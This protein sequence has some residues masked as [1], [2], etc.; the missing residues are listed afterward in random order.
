MRL[1]TGFWDAFRNASALAA[2]TGVSCVATSVPVTS[3]GV[4]SCAING[5]VNKNE[6]ARAKM[7]PLRRAGLAQGIRLVRRF[8][9][10][11][12]RQSDHAGL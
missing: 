12:H 1:A 4:C 3:T 5:S 11:V 7:P 9:L 6:K 8:M 10:R 2:A